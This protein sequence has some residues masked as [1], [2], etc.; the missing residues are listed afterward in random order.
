MK[1]SIG[2]V[3]LFFFSLGNLQASSRYWSE[4]EDGK[5]CIHS[6]LQG[7]TNGK[8]DSTFMVL[9]MWLSR[10][11][12]ANNLKLNKIEAIWFSATS[13]KVAVNAVFGI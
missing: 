10:E 5:I 8:K 12:K 1:L 9:T 7:L 2:L 3:S 11:G 13:H 4:L 6:P